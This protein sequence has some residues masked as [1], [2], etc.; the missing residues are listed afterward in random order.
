MIKSDLP[1]RVYEKDGSYYYVTAIG[2]K[3]KWTKL[4]RVK[5]GLP[6]LYRAIAELTATD[7]MDDSI[8]RL[9]GDWLL[10][11]SVT[12]AKKTQENDAYMCRGWARP[13]W[14]S[15]AKKFHR[16]TW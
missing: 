3:R 16:P 11:V 10:E 5:Q 12:H 15:G 8:T 13:L 6:A 7:T 14:N 2:K 1:K 9:I 4:C